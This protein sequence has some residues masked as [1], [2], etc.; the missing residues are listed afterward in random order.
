MRV[1]PGVRLGIFVG[2]AWSAAAAR[3]CV[4]RI[5]VIV[6]RCVRAVVGMFLA[7][8]HKARVDVA[9]LTLLDGAAAFLFYIASPSVF[10]RSSARS[11][12]SEGSFWMS[13]LLH[14][15]GIAWYF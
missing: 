11:T 12:G 14:R 3:G 7:H 13:A 5:D 2:L 9:V 10:R 4:I 15:T 6:F 1:V 8:R